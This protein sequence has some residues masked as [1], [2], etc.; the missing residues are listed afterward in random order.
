MKQRNVLILMILLLPLLATAQFYWPED[1]APVRQ[2][3]HL[4]WN[5]AAISAGDDVALF[6]YDCLRD[7]TRDVMGTRIA[8]NGEH[9]WGESGRVIAGNTS[10]QRAPVVAAYSDGSVLVVWEDYSV[11]RFRD[12]M[13]QRY[14]VNG[15]PLWS[16]SSGVI[17]VQQERDQ[18]DAKVSINDNGMAYVVFTDDRL[19]EGADLR[20]NSY[21]QILTSDGQRVGPID[22]IQLLFRA[23]AY[24]Q[25]LDVACIGADAYILNT[26]NT[27]TND[28]V[29]QKLSP[30]GMR[31]F[32]NDDAVAQYADFGYHRLIAVGNSLVLAWAAG[33]G[34]GYGDARLTMLDT[35]LDPLPGWSTEGILLA[36]GLNAQ[37]IRAMIAAPYGG[38][39]AALASYEFDPDV[40]ALTL[41]HVAMN[42]AIGWGPVPFGTAALRTSPLDW[43][44][45][46]DELLV[47]YD[48][49]RD[50]TDYIAHTQKLSSGG[51]KLWGND[52]NIV[53]ERPGKKIRIEV[54]KPGDAPARMIVVSGRTILQ[55]ESLF[56][57][58]LNNNGLPTG[59]PD[60]LSGGLTYDIYDQTAAVMGDNR[61]V[62]I[63]SDSRATI[64]RD[65]YYQVT[66]R[67]GNALLELNGRKLTQAENF[68]IYDPPSAA[69][70]GAGGAFISWMIDSLGATVNLF[71]Q[72]IDEN[73]TLMWSVPTVIPNEHG[74]HGDTYLVPDGSG[75][76]FVAFARFSAGFV[77]R[78]CVAHIDAAGNLNWPGDY[79]EFPDASSN[80]ALLTGAT[81]D[82]N[83]GVFVAGI[84][85][86]WTD[87]QAILYHL[88][89]SGAFGAG[90]SNA[91]RVYGPVNSRERNSKLLQI[92]GRALLTYEVPQGQNSALYHVYGMLIA[93]DGAEQWSVPRR[94][95]AVDAAV[96]RHYVTEDRQGGFFLLYEDFRNGNAS[97]LYLARYNDLAQEM[98]QG[99]E[100]RVC[101]HNGEQSHGT[102]ASDGNGGAW[103]AWE[104]YR[105]SDL[106]AEID[107]Y[108]THINAMGEH[109]TVNGFSWPAD[110]YPICDV[111]TY[112][113][114]PEL[115]S[116]VAGSALAVW[117]D[118]R[119][120][121]PGRCC[122]AGAVGDIF[123]NI[124]G[125]VLSEVSL[126][127]HE[128]HEAELPDEFAL[129]AY[130]NPFNPNAQLTFSL[131]QNAR[132]TLKIY[133]TLGQVVQSL[134]DEQMIAGTHSLNWNASAQT[135]GLYFA[136]LET[137]AG[138]SVVTKLALIK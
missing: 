21:A 7:G 89:A 30:D 107:I 116:W 38:V 46:G 56:V 113:Q 117:K 101:S 130:P 47:A 88:E 133:N 61:M 91:G 67:H 99:V 68:S 45:D 92:D 138:L 8:A 12:L 118:L 50:L 11:G 14:D 13:A 72:H 79:Y 23:E 80:D 109:A 58:E 121:N 2:G 131:T 42:G 115:H 119:S 87:T 48:E 122:G 24:N 19:T 100:R 136:K 28:L 104:D 1:G 103:I 15:T 77:A 9:S 22:G 74:F 108:G 51:A 125:Q 126:D 3:A 43:L 36:D 29:I 102:I 32:P 137:D 65:I 95:S 134:L 129:N 4:G 27:A 59:T 66:D 76:V 18:F 64:G 71:V 60:F 110:G 57:V 85:G 111:P 112:Q 127:A 49:L 39:V 25:P 90:W 53:W 114:E 94:L 52:G 69:S 106:Y 84:V 81:S 17:V 135:S 63:W 54:E 75:G 86:P 20:L 78:I 10:E 123:N 55:P 96:V 97:H 6:Y 128:E 73:G 105:N 34:D 41:Y 26:M 132:A 124:Y 70:D 40:S 93:R 44:W 98:W 35:N 16:P 120:S 5:G 31:G 37:N 83:G 33:G 82:G 62:T